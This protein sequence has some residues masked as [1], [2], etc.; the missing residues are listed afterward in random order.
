MAQAGPS[1]ARKTTKQNQ[2]QKIKKVKKSFSSRKT[3]ELL[4]KAALEYVG[5]WM[6]F[7]ALD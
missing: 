1:S 7:S 6:Q 3:V 4:E 2:N 5:D